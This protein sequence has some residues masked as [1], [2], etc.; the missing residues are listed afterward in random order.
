M[1]THTRPYMIELTTPT[2]VTR[3]LVDAPTEAAAIRH[4]VRDSIK[5]ARPTKTELITLV[6]AGLKLEAAVIDPAAKKV[7]KP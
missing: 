7:R 2:G 5:I 6:Q 1:T 4:V 3:R